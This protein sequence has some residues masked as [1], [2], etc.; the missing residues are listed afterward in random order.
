MKNHT[1]VLGLGIASSAYV[2][3]LDY[4]KVK[5]EVKKKGEFIRIKYTI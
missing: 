2:S 4:N 1:L 3:L 5:D